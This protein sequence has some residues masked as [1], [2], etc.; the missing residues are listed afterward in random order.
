MICEV[1]SRGSDFTASGG[2]LLTGALENI[3][4]FPRE[5]SKGGGFGYLPVDKWEKE[6]HFMQVDYWVRM[7]PVRIFLD[8]FCFLL[9][10]TRTWDDGNM[11]RR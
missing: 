2:I 5:K 7:G 9:T 4:T 11:S 8:T 6:R 10:G 1:C 3:G